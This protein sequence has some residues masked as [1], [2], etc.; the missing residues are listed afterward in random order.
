MNSGKGVPA[1][2]AEG[3][4]DSLLFGTTTRQG[5]EHPI[6]SDEF[7]QQHRRAS[8][9]SMGVRHSAIRANCRNVWLLR[10]CFVPAIAE[11][12]LAALRSGP[13]W[14]VGGRC[15]H[16]FGHSIS[17]GRIGFLLCSPRRYSYDAW[18]VSATTDYSYHAMPRLH[19][20]QIFTT[21]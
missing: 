17:S 4:S 5:L 9:V 19:K 8:T 18:L 13:Q 7:R 6:I 1:L 3:V 20:L 11:S 10:M 15:I 12:L 2:I 14:P 21:G 16:A